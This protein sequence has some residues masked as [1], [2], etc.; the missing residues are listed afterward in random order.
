[1][2]SARISSRQ[3]LSNVRSAVTGPLASFV[4]TS[5]TIP[6]GDVGQTFALVELPW[7][8]SGQP[9]LLTS[10]APSPLL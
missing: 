9:T 5:L 8:A 10:S 3:Q 2:A 1:V 4:T 6:V 7:P